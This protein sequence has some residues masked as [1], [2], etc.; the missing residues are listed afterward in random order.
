[1]GSIETVLPLKLNLVLLA[2]LNDSTKAPV[3]LPVRKE[4]VP[5]LA[6]IASLKVATKFMPRSATA[7]ATPVAEVLALTK[8]G[9]VLSTGNAAVVNEK[10]ALLAKALLALSFTEPAENTTK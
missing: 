3:A 9:A 4:I 6:L 1:M 2:T 8:V 5:V 10:L 7:T